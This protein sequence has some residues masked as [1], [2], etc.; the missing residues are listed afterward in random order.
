MFE[1]KDRKKCLFQSPFS[2]VIL[3][4]G[5]VAWAC[6]YWNLHVLFSSKLIP[7]PIFFTE[8]INNFQ[9]EH[10]I[11]IGCW[12]LM[13]FNGVLTLLILPFLADNWIVNKK[14]G[15]ETKLGV[16]ILVLTFIFFNIIIVLITTLN[17]LGIRP[18]I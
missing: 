7:F 3:L 13:V 14:R 8:V 2:F 15:T 5:M 16:R 1:K 6:D 9:N 11:T 18:T 10:A 4:L 17:A 12:V